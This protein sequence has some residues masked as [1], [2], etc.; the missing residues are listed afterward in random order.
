MLTLM[1]ALAIGLMFALPSVTSRTNAGRAKLS[2]R[3]LIVVSPL[4]WNTSRPI[5]ETRELRVS[6]ENF[7]Y[8]DCYQCF[9]SHDSPM[10]RGRN[11]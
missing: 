8:Q 11:V 6:V 3:A 4:Q 2:L 5:A 1:A 7:R 10:V 9:Q